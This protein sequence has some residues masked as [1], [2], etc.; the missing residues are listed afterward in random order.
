MLVFRGEVKLEY[1]EKTSQCIE[2]NQQTQLTY[3]AGS[4]NQTRATLVGGGCSH[5]CAI[6]PPQSEA[7]HL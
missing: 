5:H 1:L 2:E 7:R 6:P 4:G 3:D